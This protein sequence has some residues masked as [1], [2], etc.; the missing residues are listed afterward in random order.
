VTAPVDPLTVIF[1]ARIDGEPE[2]RFDTLQDAMSWIE[3]LD[4]PTGS[5]DYNGMPVLAY[6]GGNVDLAT[7]GPQ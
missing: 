5:V 6:V 4:E 2:H 7:V 3:T 1:H